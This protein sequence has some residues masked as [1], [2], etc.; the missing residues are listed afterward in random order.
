M[1]EEVQ[2]CSVCQ[3][4]LRKSAFVCA[5]P[6]AHI[7]HVQCLHA[8]WKV[9]IRCPKLQLTALVEKDLAMKAY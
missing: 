2:V 4:P 8:A 7:F 6:Y 5:L 3:D 9:S 1:E